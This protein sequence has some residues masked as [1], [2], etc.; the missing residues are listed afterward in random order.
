MFVPSELATS[1]E[2]YRPSHE[3]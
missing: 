1:G 3:K 2:V